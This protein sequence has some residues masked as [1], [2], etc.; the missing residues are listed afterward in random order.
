MNGFS[1]L[2]TFAL[3]LFPF[4]FIISECGYGDWLFDKDIFIV[5]DISKV[6]QFDDI[7]QMEKDKIEFH[8][9]STDGHSWVKPVKRTWDVNTQLTPLP[10]RMKAHI[11]QEADEI[12]QM[13]LEKIKRDLPILVS[14]LENIIEEEGGECRIDVGKFNIDEVKHAHELLDSIYCYMSDN[15]SSMITNIF[16]ILDEPETN[17]EQ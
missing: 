6:D 14:K 10:T 15:L 13:Q 11:S 9:K 8:H 16:C 4:V 17:V 1:F 2:L 12:C 5:R 3:F 7:A